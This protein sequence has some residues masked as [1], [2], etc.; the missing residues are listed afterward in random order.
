MLCYYFTIT[1]FVEG[2][3]TL[4]YTSYMVE[5]ASR[6]RAWR[7]ATAYAIGMYGLNLHKVELQ[8]ISTY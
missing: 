3:K 7:K 2:V 5:D 6:V 1:F 4:Q 8:T